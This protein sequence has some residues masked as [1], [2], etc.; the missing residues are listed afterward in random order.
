V[1]SVEITLIRGSSNAIGAMASLGLTR[2]PICKN[3]IIFQ[4][5]GVEPAIPTR[6]ARWSADRTRRAPSRGRSWLGGISNQ[7]GRITGRR[8]FDVHGNLTPVTSRTQSI[9]SRTEKTAPGSEIQKI[10]FSALAKV[11]Q[12]ADMRVSQID[13]MNV[14]S[15]RRSVRRR[16]VVCRRPGPP[17][18]T[19]RRRNHVGDQVRFRF[20]PFSTLLRCAG[21]IE[22][23]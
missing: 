18:I 22:I 6:N 4:L 17:A 8:R 7:P 21:G 3:Q 16:I 19:Q 12:G 13:D 14:I 23:A 20:V 11:L 9:T 5:T 10:R 15:D 1:K 2:V